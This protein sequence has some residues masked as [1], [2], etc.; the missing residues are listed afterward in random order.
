MTPF[1]LYLFTN[2]L[3]TITPTTSQY[4]QS[5][6]MHIP[7]PKYLLQWAVLLLYNSERGYTPHRHLLWSSI[8]VVLIFLC[9]LL[10]CS[11]CTGDPSTFYCSSCSSTSSQ[12][13]LLFFPPVFLPFPQRILAFLLNIQV[14]F[15]L[16]R[17]LARAKV[18]HA[19]AIVLMVSITTRLP[20]SSL[21]PLHLHIS[22]RLYYC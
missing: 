7:S 13:I 5:H 3:Q 8:L 10:G 9:H 20:L 17:F 15:D 18:T 14:Y 11:T 2:A 16:F 12:C 21:P 1:Q 22:R 4:T 6:L 19:T